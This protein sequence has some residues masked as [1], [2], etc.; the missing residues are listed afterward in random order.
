MDTESNKPSRRVTY[1]R[2]RWF[3][4]PLFRA[5]ARKVGTRGT[6]PLDPQQTAVH[7]PG[8][9]GQCFASLLTPGVILE[10]IRCFPDT[11]SHL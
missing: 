10:S 3:L 1:L 6:S 5:S 4:P 2:D 11:V 7:I 8:D 9:T